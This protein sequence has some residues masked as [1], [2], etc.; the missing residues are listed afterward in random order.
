[1]KKS[2]LN[3][4]TVLNKEQ[5]RNINGGDSLTNLQEYCGSLSIVYYSLTNDPEGDGISAE[6]DALATQTLIQ[7]NTHCIGVN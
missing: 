6:N 5:Q 4:G 3:I 1:M 7:W 2:I